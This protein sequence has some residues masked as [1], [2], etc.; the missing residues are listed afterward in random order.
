MGNEDKK[1][2][3]EAQEEIYEDRFLFNGENIQFD[4]GDEH[5]LGTTNSLE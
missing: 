5:L 4:N 1:K 3:E 2:I